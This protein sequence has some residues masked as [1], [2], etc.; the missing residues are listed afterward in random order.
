M[1]IKGKLVDDSPGIIDF[2]PGD[3]VEIEVPEADKTKI[4]EGDTVWAQLIVRK[5]GYCDFSASTWLDSIVAHFPKKA[6]KP[7][8]PEKMDTKYGK[9][10]GREK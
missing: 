4:K 8:V 1:R 2:A 10:G 3:I 5:N 9:I 7:E 6:E